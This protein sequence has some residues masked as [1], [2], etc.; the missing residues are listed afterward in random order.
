MYYWSDVQYQVCVPSCRVGFKF[1]KEEDFHPDLPSTPIPIDIACHA[2]GVQ[3][4]YN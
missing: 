4:T 2:V 1:N 3:R